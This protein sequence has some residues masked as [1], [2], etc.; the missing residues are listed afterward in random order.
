MELVQRTM[1]FI[2]TLGKRPLQPLSTRIFVRLLT[3]VVLLRL[4]LMWQTRVM[5]MGVHE[6]QIPNGRISGPLLLPARFATHQ[7]NTFFLLAIVFLLIHLF[8]R[9]N[10]WTAILFSI[11]TFNL[12]II[13]IP[14][15]DGGDVL[16]FMLSLWAIFFVPLQ[17]A[18]SPRTTMQI[19]LY[20]C[21]RIGCM[22]QFVFMYAA[23]GADKLSSNAWVTGQAFERMRRAGGIINPDFPSW[24]STPFW[25]FAF[26]WSAIL[27]E[28]LFAILIW[29]RALQ[30][31]L[32]ITAIIFHLGIWWMMDLGDFSGI[33]I[34][35]VM[36]FIRD[37]QYAMMFRPALL[38]A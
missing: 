33:M 32:I 4:L 2:A 13:T 20:N 34:V 11:L 9:R 5:I 3:A 1:S 31:S 18:T 7:P 26:S 15:G 10:Y 29:F 6:L 22:L 24:L 21:A 37:D 35:A 16:T 25:D 17:S 27:I 8:V 23:S 19:L 14:N 12:L 30:P 36:I 38:S 28:I